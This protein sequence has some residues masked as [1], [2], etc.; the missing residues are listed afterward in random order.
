MSCSSI[1]MS[2]QTTLMKEAFRLV[3]YFIIN[4]LHV[5]YFP[6]YKTIFKY[7]LFRVIRT[8]MVPRRTTVLYKSGVAEEHV[9]MVQDTY[10]DSMYEVCSLSD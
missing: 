5:L 7:S 3:H 1:I 10:E 9:S 6:Y 2:L 8:D 4:L